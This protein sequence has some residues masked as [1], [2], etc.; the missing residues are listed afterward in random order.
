[1]KSPDPVTM[2]LFERLR[3]DRTAV[4]RAELRAMLVGVLLA[5]IFVVG[6]STVAFFA[7]GPTSGF[8][9]LATLAFVCL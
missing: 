4:S 2:A 1:M 8:V 5:K 3:V 6:L 7:M 9:I